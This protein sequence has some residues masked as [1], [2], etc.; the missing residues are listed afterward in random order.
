MY[1]A[2][3]LNPAVADRIWYTCKCNLKLAHHVQ[4]RRVECCINSLSARR[5]VVPK[6]YPRRLVD[7]SWGKCYLWCQIEWHRAQS[8]QASR[9]LGQTKPLCA[10]LVLS[11]LPGGKGNDVIASHLKKKREVHCPIYF[12]FSI[13]ML[14]GVHQGDYSFFLHCRSIYWEA[15]SC[16]PVSSLIFAPPYW[17][18]TFWVICSFLPQFWQIAKVKVLPGWPARAGTTA[19]RRKQ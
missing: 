4:I 1:E 3:S 13:T 17:R 18:P 15:P 14:W 6:S 8:T 12:A 19:H 5:L 11:S 7:V 2:G 10:W 9:C 16:G